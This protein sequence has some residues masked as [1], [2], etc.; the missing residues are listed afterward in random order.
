[1]TCARSF[2]SSFFIFIHSFKSNPHI[3]YLITPALPIP[4]LSLLSI[5]PMLTH[6]CCGWMNRFLHLQRSNES[7][8]AHFK[9]LSFFHH[10]III[11]WGRRAPNGREGAT[12]KYKTE[13][14]NLLN[15][16]LQAI[17][18]G[19]AKYWCFVKKI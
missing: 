13:L 4:P 7:F 18:I 6:I 10:N 16:Y 14:L 8:V 2:H 11:F 17:R 15:K 3:H 9:V 5:R 19:D 12:L 1:M